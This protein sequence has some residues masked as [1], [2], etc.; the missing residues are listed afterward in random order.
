MTTT[1]N[2]K[3]TT[4][5]SKTDKIKVTPAMM[6]AVASAMGARRWANVPAEERV[7]FTTWVASHGAGRPRTKAKR[8]P[9]G[10]FTLKAAKIRA[11]RKDGTGLGHK[12]GCSF[13]RDTPYRTMG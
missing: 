9:C 1:M 2:S 10:A 6:S 3:K 8:C 4:S 13:Y 7:R 12:P 11:S 5:D